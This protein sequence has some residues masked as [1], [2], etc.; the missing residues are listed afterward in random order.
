MG[1]LTSCKATWN[2]LALSLGFADAANPAGVFNAS[3]AVNLAVLYFVIGLPRWLAP[4]WHLATLHR[5][6]CLAYLEVFA[7]GSACR[8]LA[9]VVGIPSSMW[10]PATLVVA[11][12]IAPWMRDMPLLPFADAPEDKL[13]GTAWGVALENFGFVDA[14]SVARLFVFYSMGLILHPAEW[15]QGLAKCRFLVSAAALTCVAGHF[16]WTQL[17]TPY[18]AAT[19]QDWPAY[20][21]GYAYP[22]RV[23]ADASLAVLLMLAALGDSVLHRAAAFLGQFLV[24]TYL[25]HLY[26]FPNLVLTLSDAASSAGVGAL[27]LTLFLM[28]PLYV[29]SLGRMAQ[30]LLTTLQVA[31]LALFSRVPPQGAKNSK[32]Q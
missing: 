17:E 25:V 2:A 19:Q 29:L 3:R 32:A 15:L 26:I 7:I 30:A 14:A 27:L 11:A 6:T 24:G 10:L 22:L 9:H 23:L 12:A 28:P 8:G 21:S 5:W 1:G 18:D 16:A 31:G 4:S 20:Y 13:V